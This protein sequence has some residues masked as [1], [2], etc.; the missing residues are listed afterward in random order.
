MDI[1]V[2]KENIRRFTKMIA[3]EKDDSKR[4]TLMGLL[5]AERKNLAAA[6]EARRDKRN[7]GQADG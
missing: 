1:F 2:A 3:E 6:E 4:R 7:N 5:E